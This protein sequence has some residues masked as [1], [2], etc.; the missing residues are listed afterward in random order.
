MDILTYESFK[1][2]VVEYN[3]KISYKTFENLSKE[4]FELYN[5]L[6]NKRLEQ[7]RLPFTYISKYFK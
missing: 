5:S 3:L 4:E 2:F 7:E 6:Y 1:D